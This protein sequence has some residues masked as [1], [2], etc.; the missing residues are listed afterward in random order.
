MKR[1]IDPED[2]AYFL[3]CVDGYEPDDGNPPEWVSDEKL[4]DRAKAIVAGTAHPTY[5]DIDDQSDYDDPWAVVAHVY[6]RMG[7]GI[8]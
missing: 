8:T 3:E 4:W 5:E 7:G 2:V 1:S 6:E